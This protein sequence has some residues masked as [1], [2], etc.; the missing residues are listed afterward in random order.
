MKNAVSIHIDIAELVFVVS[1][2]PQDKKADWLDSFVE[3]LVLKNGKNDFADKLLRDVVEFQRIKGEKARNSA[4]ARWHKEDNANECERMQQHTV[5]CESMRSDA[6]DAKEKNREEKRRTE[7]KERINTYSEDFEIFW[8]EYK[9]KEGNGSKTN[10]YKFW[11]KLTESEKT[12]AVKMLPAYKTSARETQFMQQAERY[13]REKT[14][15]GINT[16]EDSQP[17]K[18]M[19]VVFS[20]DPDNIGYRNEK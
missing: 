6:N 4:N 11:N 2:I 3:S 19:K 5:E 7:K 8:S 20:D 14:W 16:E 1:K 9:R 13:L 12:D 10:A 15:E 17:Q 18:Q